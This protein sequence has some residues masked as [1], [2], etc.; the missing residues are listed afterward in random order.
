MIIIVISPNPVHQYITHAK[1]VLRSFELH[2]ISFE[3]NM[4]LDNCLLIVSTEK[5]QDLIQCF[6]KPLE[7][8]LRLSGI[9]IQLTGAND[10][11]QI[12]DL[13]D[14]LLEFITACL[15]SRA[16]GVTCGALIAGVESDGNQ[17]FL[18]GVPVLWSNLEMLHGLLKE[19]IRD[20][21]VIKKSAG[22]SVCTQED[23]EAIMRMVHFA[24]H[25]VNIQSSNPGSDTGVMSVIVLVVIP[26]WHVCQNQLF[27]IKNGRKQQVYQRLGGHTALVKG[28]Q[29]P[30]A[31]EKLAS[32]FDKF[33]KIK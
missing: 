19:K 4:P 8:K 11:E 24:R 13:V 20:C 6:E 25:E 22:Q 21:L 16:S 15:N 12:T 10:F 30:E 33:C 2:A 29:I 27:V 1:I 9:D 28:P 14:E 32:E 5:I 7:D 23:T 31:Q 17:Y 3:V 26:D 18:N